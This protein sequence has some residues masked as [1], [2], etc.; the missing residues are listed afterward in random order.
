MSMNKS[1]LEK[2]KKKI[3]EAIRAGKSYDNIARK[4]HTSKTTI[5]ELRKKHSSEKN[6]YR[7]P[8][9]TEKNKSPEFLSYLIYFSLMLLWIMTI[10]NRPVTVDNILLSITYFIV[11]VSAFYEMRRH[12]F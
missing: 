12:R 9:K 6:F 8:S 4:Y 10:Y 2:K 5:R 3:L 11:S 7:I 1:N